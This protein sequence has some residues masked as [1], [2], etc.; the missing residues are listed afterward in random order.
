LALTSHTG[1]R[2]SACPAA[3][4]RAATAWPGSFASFPCPQG[5]GMNGA[6]TTCRARQTA[7]VRC[8]DGLQ[9]I[10]RTLDH[11]F[12]LRSHVISAATSKR[13]EWNQLCRSCHFS[14]EIGAYSIADPCRQIECAIQSILMPFAGRLTCRYAIY[15]EQCA[16][17][18][19]PLSVCP[20][21]AAWLEKWSVC[22]CRQPVPAW[23]FAFSWPGSG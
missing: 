22:Q 5:Q 23:T 10:S 17:G 8:R 21:F 13:V 2:E 1:Q 9:I 12:G 15:L 14:V 20:V 3:S 6:A 4:L 16:M 11:D 18:T 19:V 7:I